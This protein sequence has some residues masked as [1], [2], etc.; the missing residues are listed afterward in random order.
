MPDFL[1]LVL[2]A[3]MLMTLVVIWV[4]LLFIVLNDEGDELVDD[5][6]TVDTGLRYVDPYRVFRY[7]LALTTIAIPVP[8]HHLF[9]LLIAG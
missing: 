7:L 3:L 4:G 8:L 9:I 2:T 6:D 1:E 5:F